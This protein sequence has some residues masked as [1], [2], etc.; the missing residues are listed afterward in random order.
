MMKIKHVLIISA[1]VLLV[2]GIGFLLA[3]VWS[4]G[5]FAITLEP[6]GAMA[7]QLL[8]ATFLGFAALNWLGRNYVVPEDVRS[9][10]LAN[11]VMNTVSFVALLIQKLDGLGNAW[12]WIPILLYLLFAVAYGYSLVFKST[13]EEPTM[14]A[15]HA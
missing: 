12:S 5:L 6:G 14:R 13:Y 1:F 8:A 4:M 2:F 3:P 9:I 7:T 15:K 11:F 10:I